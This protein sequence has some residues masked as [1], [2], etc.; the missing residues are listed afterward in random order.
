MCLKATQSKGHLDRV[1]TGD[2]CI[3]HDSHKDI[4]VVI[5]RHDAM[6]KHKPIQ[7]SPIA[8]YHSIVSN[9][10]KSR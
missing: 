4:K 2:Q 5:D 1:C 3:K 9:Y 8:A 7:G 6:S 10:L